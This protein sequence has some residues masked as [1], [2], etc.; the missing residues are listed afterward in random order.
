M[1]RRAKSRPLLKRRRAAR[2]AAVQALYQIEQNDQPAAQVVAEFVAHRLEQLLQPFMPEVES[3]SVDEEWF[4]LVVLGAWAAHEELD[5]RIGNCLGPSWTLHRCG[6]F[7]RACLRAGG[8]ELAER[9]DVATSVVISEYVEVTRL[10]V[11]GDEPAFVHAVL[12][13]LGRELRPAASPD[14]D[15]PES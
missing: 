12:D 2:L 3:P 7:L 15:P 9:S 10:F 6:Y 13:R 8:F 5:Q 4:K 14:A 11:G 1:S